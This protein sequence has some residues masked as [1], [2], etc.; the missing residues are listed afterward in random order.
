[1]SSYGKHFVMG[2][3]ASFVT[4]LISLLHVTQT[5]SL[6]FSHVSF[7]VRY[8]HPCFTKVICRHNCGC[9]NIITS[10][11]QVIQSIQCLESFP[12]PTYAD[13]RTV[14]RTF[15]LFCSVFLCEAVGWEL[16]IEQ[17]TVPQPMR[18]DG[19]WGRSALLLSTWRATYLDLAWKP[20][21]MLSWITSFRCTTR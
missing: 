16:F 20:K 19:F 11:Q 7:T 4:R 15:T 5:T 9:S 18:F 1:M 17:A 14:S 8:C 10:S 6:S 2:F 12:R 3:F 21:K 13:A